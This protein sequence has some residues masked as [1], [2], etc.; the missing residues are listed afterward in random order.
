MIPDARNSDADADSGDGRDEAD[1]ERLDRNENEILQELRVT[2]TGT[3]I[4][5]WA[6]PGSEKSGREPVE[7]G[8][9]INRH[10][11]GE[12]SPFGFRVWS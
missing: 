1:T 5:L 3:Q 2:Q 8:E 9:R 11:H 12:K 7:L 10:S 6:L 4:L